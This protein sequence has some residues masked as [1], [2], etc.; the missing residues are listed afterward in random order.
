[1]HIY[2]TVLNHLLT[3]IQLFV[4]TFHLYFCISDHLLPHLFSIIYTYSLQWLYL[5]WTMIV[6][7]TIYFNLYCLSYSCRHCSISPHTTMTSTR[8][9]WRTR[10]AD[11]ISCISCNS[12][13]KLDVLSFLLY[14]TMFGAQSSDSPPF[15]EQTIIS[16][17][18][19]SQSYWYSTIIVKS[20]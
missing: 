8:V 4:M 3:Y 17:V 14:K 7:S 6:P 18:C 16:S 13:S 1:M 15:H 9:W 19:W 2:I 10:I 20:C 5:P 12:R 11:L